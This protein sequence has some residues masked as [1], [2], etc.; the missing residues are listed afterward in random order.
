MTLLTNKYLNG[1]I[2][3]QNEKYN[4]IYP[5]PKWIIFCKEMIRRGW[6]VKLHAA[7]TTVSKYIYLE[8]GKYNIKVRF[9]NHKANK[10]KELNKDSDFYVGKGNKG[11]ITTDQLLNKLLNFETV[12]FVKKL[13]EEKQNR[14]SNNSVNDYIE[15]CV[16]ILKDNNLKFSH[17]IITGILNWSSKHN[18][19]TEKQTIV[20]E[21]I[22]KYKKQE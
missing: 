1:C 10:I 14:L 6:V 7:K 3:R 5:I 11:V 18:A 9:S 15:K 20:I 19:L 22:L 4:G 12:D 21:N 17:N 2:K 8:K 16:E 13:N